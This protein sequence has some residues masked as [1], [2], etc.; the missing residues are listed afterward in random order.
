VHCLRSL[1]RGLAHRRRRPNTSRRSEAF[2]TKTIK[3]AARARQPM[4]SICNYWDNAP[5]R[6]TRDLLQRAEPQTERSPIGGNLQQGTSKGQLRGIEQPGRSHA[7]KTKQLGGEKQKKKTSAATPESVLVRQLTSDTEGGAS[8]FTP[9]LR[10]DRK[11][12]GSTRGLL[13]RMIEGA[14]A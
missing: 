14:L 6:T 5:D 3:E 8:C 9:N 7:I 11:R 10:T 12:R 1:L 4:K 13:L 2:S